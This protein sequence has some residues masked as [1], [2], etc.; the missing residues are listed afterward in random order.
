MFQEQ[1]KCLRLLSENKSF[2]FLR[3]FSQSVGILRCYFKYR[4]AILITKVI[5]IFNIIPI[6]S[7]SSTLSSYIIILI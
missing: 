6:F 1:V 2:D 4:Y 7:I 5:R 3:M